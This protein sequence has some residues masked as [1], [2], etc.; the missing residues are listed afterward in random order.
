METPP[1]HLILMIEYVYTLVGSIKHGFGIKLNI[2]LTGQ[3]PIWM[4][5]DP[6]EGMKIGAFDFMQPPAARLT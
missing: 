5:N 6:H 3:C 4:G 2:F 1:P